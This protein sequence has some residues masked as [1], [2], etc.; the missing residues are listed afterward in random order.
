MLLILTHENSDFDAVASQLAA[1]KLY[2]Q[3]VPLLSWRV[4]R[5][6]EQFLALYWDAFEFVRPDDWRRQR[7][8]RVVLVDTLAL[9][10]VRGM[11]PDKVRVQV[12]DHHELTNDPQNN[13]TYH[14]EPVGAATTLLVEM[15]QSAGMSLTANEATL[16]LLGIHEDTGSLLYDTTTVRDTRAA[17]WLLEQGAQVSVIRRFLD[18]AL[19]EPQLRLYESLQEE[20]EW[21]RVEGQTILLGAVKAPD[22]FDDEISAVAHR[23]RDALSP[24]GMILLVQLKYNHVQLVARS[25]TD[26]VDVSVIARALGGGGH[27]RAAAATIMD[28]SLDDVRAEVIDLLPSATKP[29]AKVSQI[30]SYGVHT[31]PSTTSVSSAA[32]QMQRSGHEGYPVV[33]AED[34]ELVGLLSRRIVDRAMNHRLGELP[35]SQIMKAGKVTVRP[36][37]SVEKLQR[38]M[39]EEG[40]GQVP[41]VEER[42]GADGPIELIGIVTRTDLINLLTKSGEDAGFP[43]MSQLLEKNLSPGVWSLVLAAGRAA[44]EMNMALYFVGG[45]VR[46]LLLGVKAKDIDMVVEG[47]AIALVRHMRQQYGGDIRSH[48]QFGTAKWLLNRRV[49]RKLIEEEKVVGHEAG[50]APGSRPMMVDFVTARSEFYTQPTA[51]PEVERGSIKLDLHRRD[52][53]IHT[54]AVRLDGAHLGE[55][56]DFY[57]GKRDLDSKLIR[58]LH[59]LSFVD[60]PTRILRAVRLE[61]RLGFQIESRTAELI[62]SALP[63]LNRVTGERIRNELALCLEEPKRSEMLARLAEIGV[64]RRIHPDFSWQPSTAI[65]LANAEVV[66][67]DPTWQ[68]ALGSESA[69]F[70]YFALILLPLKVHVRQEVM[71]RLKVRKGTRDDVGAVQALLDHLTNLDAS[72]RPSDVVK[73]LR[74]YAPRVLLVAV[75]QIGPDSTVGQ[76]ISQYQSE[77]RNVRTE[78]NGNDL[79]AMGLEAG[80]KVGRL[81]DRLLAARLDGEVDDVAGERALLEKVLDE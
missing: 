60:D 53:T 5:N 44:G 45:L 7:V 28:R 50:T 77:W 30:M 31:V 22:G 21:L 8:S 63:M 68:D 26:R 16:L 36:S 58:V 10:S 20:A 15:L 37:D 32:N 71:H 39:I 49:W 2:P 1:H 34:G 69:V 74:P 76:L 25:G 52:F 81:L 57:G 75:S 13:W 66:L 3:G 43:D 6:V 70:V 40:W 55:L 27:S 47:D 18:I 73:H 67:A 12:I 64:L 4:N 79:L 9:P 23:L 78:L 42:N 41:V 56:L 65:K 29:T 51:L 17:A 19:S 61:Q 59:S 38:L 54:I 14:T 24:D 35:V 62:D 33:S 72:A 46:D 80:P 48:A 11:R